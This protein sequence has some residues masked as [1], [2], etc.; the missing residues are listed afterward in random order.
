MLELIW[1]EALS[2]PFR[3]L[4]EFLDAG[5]PVLYVIFVAAVILWTL[6]IE[7]YWFF[8]RQHPRQCSTYAGEWGRR[9]DKRSWGARRIREELLSRAKL[10]MTATLPLIKM[11]IALCPLLGLLGTVTGMIEVFDIMAVKGTADARAMASGVSR[12]TV[13]TMA[14]MMVGISGLFFATRFDTRVRTETEL[15]A[16]RLDYT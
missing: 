7:R 10:A 16:D 9:R 6:I 1:A 5:G 2:A 8:L 11:L 13:P 12:A 3:G 15:L 4:E 14:G